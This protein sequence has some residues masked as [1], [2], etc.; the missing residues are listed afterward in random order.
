MQYPLSRMT[1]GGVS[2]IM[3]QGNGFSQRFIKLQGNRHGS[4]DLR[5]L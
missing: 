5:N 4:C 2:Q 1:K 3:P